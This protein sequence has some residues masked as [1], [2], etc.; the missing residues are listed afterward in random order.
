MI[1]LFRSSNMAMKAL[2]SI[3]PQV[4]FSTGGYSAAPVMRAAGMLKIP[5]VIHE[6]NSIPGRSNRLFAKDAKAIAITFKKSEK[7]FAGSRVVRTGLPVRKE[8][9]EIAEQPRPALD[10]SLV[11]VFGGSQGSK[12][13]NENVPAT[14]KLMADDEVDWLHSTGPKNL[15][16]VKKEVESLNLH[17]YTISPYLQAAAMGQ[18]YQCATVVVSRSGGSL[19]ELAL[20]G[21]PSVLVPLPSAAG[22]HQY[23]NA[24]E[25]ADMGAAVI[26]TEEQ[27]DPHKFSASIRE[28]IASPEKRDRARE[29]LRQWDVPDAT[30]RIVALVEEAVE[31]RK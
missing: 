8:L 10:N 20:F 9:R 23:H 28:W 11:F 2:R 12:F 21:L 29:A 17:H 30:E 15:D 22:N 31:H 13:L 16:F 19:A 25:F 5:Y 1:N 18:A 6:Q 26:Q 14:A 27:F 7:Q 3:D 24:K 4:V